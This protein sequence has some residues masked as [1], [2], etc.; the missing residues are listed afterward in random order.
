MISLW[1]ALPR[2]DLNARS[3]SHSPPDCAP[4]SLTFEKGTAN[5]RPGPIITARAGFSPFSGLLCRSRRS[6]HRPHPS[7]LVATSIKNK[8]KERNP[9]TATDGNE[10]RLSGLL[11]RENPEKPAER[12]TEWAG[13]RG[14]HDGPGAGMAGESSQGLFQCLSK[15]VPPIQDLD[16]L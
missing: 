4:F 14:G 7:F 15:K 12:I 2:A 16:R 8:R 1:R 9:L 10:S 13:Y 11:E 6:S 3:A 5:P